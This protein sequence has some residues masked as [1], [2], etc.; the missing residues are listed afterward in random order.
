MI[1]FLVKARSSPGLCPHR[2]EP[3]GWLHDGTLVDAGH[4]LYEAGGTSPRCGQ[5]HCGSERL[6]NLL[7]P[8]TGE[9][10]GVLGF[11]S[12]WTCKSVFSL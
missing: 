6:S 4:V 1:C 12:S 2:A 5:G 8:C 3:Q 11:E 7:N 9:Q 10:G